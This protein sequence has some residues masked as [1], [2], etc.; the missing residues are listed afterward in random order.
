MNYVDVV[1][2]VLM[3]LA[4]VCLLVHLR[5]RRARYIR[6]DRMSRC[7]QLHIRSEIASGPVVVAQRR[8]PVVH[9]S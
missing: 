7:L 2:L 8:R 1:V 9:V 5:R 6:I 3:A 4:D